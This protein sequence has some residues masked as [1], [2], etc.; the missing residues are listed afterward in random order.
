MID[1]RESRD[2]VYEYLI[3]NIKKNFNLEMNLLNEYILASNIVSKRKII[4][5]TFS[6]KVTAHPNLKIFLSTLIFQLNSIEYSLEELKNKVHYLR[7]RDSEL[8]ERTAV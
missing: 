2:L 8:G 4:V 3:L 5:P 6:D 1:H 7:N